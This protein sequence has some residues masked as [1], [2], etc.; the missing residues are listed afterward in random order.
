[1]YEFSY[2]GRVVRIDDTPGLY[3][4]LPASA[5]GKTYLYTLICEM[6]KAGNKT[7]IGYTYSDYVESVPLQSL[8][9]NDT[10]IIVIDRF[11]LYANEGIC[12]LL[13]EYGKTKTVIMDLKNICKYIYNPGICVIKMKEGALDVYLHKV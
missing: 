6:V 1:M 13:K 12:E 5:S 2:Y 8:V 10:K 4:C 3:R 9:A 7:A 11:D